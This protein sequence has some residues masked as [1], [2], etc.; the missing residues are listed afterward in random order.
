MCQD[1]YAKYNINERNAEFFAG[2]KLFVKRLTCGLCCTKAHEP[3]TE[4]LREI[5][6]E[7]GALQGADEPTLLPRATNMSLL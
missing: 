3:T 5:R 6:G 2:L 7:G 1:A 4:E